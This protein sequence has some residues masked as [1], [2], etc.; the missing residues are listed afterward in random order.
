MLDLSAEQWKAVERCVAFYRKAAP[1]I[2]H[3]RSRRYGPELAE[4]RHPKGWQ[5]M[6]RVNENAA[7]AV[8]HTFAEAPGTVRVPVPEGYAVDDVCARTGVQWA[9]CGDHLILTGLSDMDGLG[10]L[11]RRAN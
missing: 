5:A 11:L 9:Q 7:L 4:W 2:A 6:V 8:V 3:G 1:V 10:V